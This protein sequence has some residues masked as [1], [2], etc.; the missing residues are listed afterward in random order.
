[1]LLWVFSSR[2][3][4]FIVCRCKVRLW[5]LLV[6]CWK[7]LVV[8][9]VEMMLLLV[10]W[11]LMI[12]MLI[13]FLFGVMLIWVFFVMCSF[14]M[15]RML[16]FSGISRVVFL[17]IFIL[18]RCSFWVCLGRC[19]IEFVCIFMV[20]LIFCW[21]VGGVLVENVVL[22]QVRGMIRN[23]LSMVL[24]MIVFFVLW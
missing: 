6:F 1:M 23:N 18:C 16:I 4:I 22:V 5:L 21:C 9:G 7:V 17:L 12:L 14:S 10:R 2:F 24:C 19:I 8:L 15:C 20:L 11:L 13:C 3:F